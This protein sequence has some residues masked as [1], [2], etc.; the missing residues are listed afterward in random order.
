MIDTF[1]RGVQGGDDTAAKIEAAVATVYGGNTHLIADGTYFL[2]E[3][4][5]AESVARDP[6]TSEPKQ[7]Q[8][9]IV[10]CGG[11]G[12]SKTLYGA[13][14]WEGREHPLL[15]PT[16]GAAKI[17]AFFVDPERSRRGLATL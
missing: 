10:G 15:G 2:A 12:K 11:W 7:S 13:D 17:R 6:R 9:V 8:P 14:H 16:T 3:A 5:P 1:A 4:L